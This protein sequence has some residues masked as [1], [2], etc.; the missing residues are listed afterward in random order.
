MGKV[1]RTNPTQS[2]C[3][4]GGGEGRLENRII[5]LQIMRTHQKNFLKRDKIFMM[6]FQNK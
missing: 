4:K 3:K 1:S 2:D 5:F 6:L